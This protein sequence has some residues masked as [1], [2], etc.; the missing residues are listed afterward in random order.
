MQ[1]VHR[2][3]SDCAF[4]M[5][6]MTGRQGEKG[7]RRWKCNM[8]FIRYCNKQYLTSVRKTYDTLHCCSWYKMRVISAYAP[9]EKSVVSDKLYCTQY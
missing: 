4:G 7:T 2:L 5:Q 9:I 6:F 3:G 1:A 8:Q